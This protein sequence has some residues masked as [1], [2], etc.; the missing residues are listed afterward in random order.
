MCVRVKGPFNLLK[1][2]II[3]PENGT[4]ITVPHFLDIA[5][6]NALKILGENNNSKKVRFILTYKLVKFR[7]LGNGNDIAEEKDSRVSSSFTELFRGTDVNELYE[8]KKSHLI[9]SF[10]QERLKG[11]GWVLH[12]I[13]HL[14][15]TIANY[16][17]FQNSNSETQP[18]M[19]ISSDDEGAS[20]G[21]DIG[22]FWKDK[23]AV[24]V[25]QNKEGDPFC[26]LYAL[27][28]AHFK[29]ENHS[30]RITKVLRKQSK[31]FNLEVVCF[32]LGKDGLIRIEKQNGLKIFA[33]CAETNG[34]RV[35]ILK[36]CRD[37]NIILIL[38]KNIEGNVIGELFRI[39]HH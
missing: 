16:T 12:K 24:I 23:K 4:R 26:G 22:K 3:E 29:P 14:E 9:L 34:K 5:K 21:F 30:G 2:F 33:L 28:I 1:S 37:P 11:S 35:D 25:P 31:T 8:N 27:T 15:I 13:Y 18:D 20:G 6:L 36:P 39:Y 10:A 32:P 17:P 7:M 38:L 19:S